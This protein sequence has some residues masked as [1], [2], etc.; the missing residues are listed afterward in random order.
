[1]RDELVGLEGTDEPCHFPGKIKIYSV[2][3]EFNRKEK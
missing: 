3:G 1:M 2:N